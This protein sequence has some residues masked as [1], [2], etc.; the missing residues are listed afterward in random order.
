MLKNPQEKKFTCLNCQKTATPGSLEIGTEHRNHCP[1]CLWSQHVDLKYSGDRKSTCKKG[2]EP[3]GLTFKQE[4]VDKWGKPKQGELMIIHKCTGGEK[5]SI[6]RIA[7]DDDP[8]KILEISEK[9]KNIDEDIKK[10]LN[11]LGIKLLSETDRSEIMVQLFGKK[12]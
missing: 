5:I 11:E 12:S 4:G 8:Q 7:A 3:I 9:S 6:N 1:K 10:E 2:M